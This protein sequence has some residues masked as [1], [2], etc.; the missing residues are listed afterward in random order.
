MTLNQD[1]NGIQKWN[2]PFEVRAFM[3]NIFPIYFSQ[4]RH[5]NL[6]NWSEIWEIIGEL[7][8]I[9]VAENI[10]YKEELEECFKNAFGERYSTILN[11]IQN[12]LKQN[13]IDIKAFNS[14]QQFANFKINAYL[15]Q[16][17]IKNYN[18]F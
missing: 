12:E 9:G 15:H 7:S 14:N 4:A 5:L 8:K 11:Y 18:K 6:I 16:K 2:V 17:N 10:N 3:K 1:K 13:D